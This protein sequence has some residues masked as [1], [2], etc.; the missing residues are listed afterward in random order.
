MSKLQH[1]KFAHTLKQILPQVLL[2]KAVGQA[3]YPELELLC[4]AQAALQT[5]LLVRQYF[6]L[7]C[8]LLVP[9][10]LLK[11]TVVRRKHI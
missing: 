7:K 4:S 10:I 1:L 3:A 8:P 11:R 9:N 6:V 5:H 2:V